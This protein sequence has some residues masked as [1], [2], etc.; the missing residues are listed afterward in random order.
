M[1]IGWT[2]ILLILAVALVVLGPKRLPDAARKIGA[3][4]R[5]FR[6]A[7]Q[8]ISQ[9]IASVD[10]ENSVGGPVS[11][12]KDKPDDNRLDREVARES[13]TDPETGPSKNTSSDETAGK[14]GDDQQ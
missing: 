6:Q 2:E 4:V 10:H 11:D 12:E 3:A 13:T 5:E 14:Q 1:G 8:G 9:E 7:F